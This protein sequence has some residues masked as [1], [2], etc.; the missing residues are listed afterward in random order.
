[1][2]TKTVK[3]Q[4]V[5]AISMKTN[6]TDLMKNVGEKPNMLFEVLSKQGIAPLGPQVWCYNGCDGTDPDKEF[7]LL[8]TVPVEKQGEDSGICTF[9]TLPEFTCVEHRHNGAWS[10][11]AS[12]YE[13]LVGEVMKSGKQ[14]IGSSR[15][16]YVNCDFENPA[17][18]ITDIQLE[19]MD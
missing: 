1:M 13:K 16:I 8:I 18:C 14:I 4:L 12:V 17:N 19:V 10:E 6:L 9:I 3:E 5:C 2:E 15:E 11:F 7:D